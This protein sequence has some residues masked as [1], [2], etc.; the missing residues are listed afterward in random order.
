MLKV[1]S[2][3]SGMELKSRLDLT[4]IFCDVDHFYQSFEHYCRSIPQLTAIAGEKRCNSR[5]S[6]SE[7]MTIVT[8][9][10]GS[11]YKTF[12]ENFILSRYNR[13]GKRHSLIW[14]VTTVLSS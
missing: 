10:H 11:G 9:F 8:A 14:L 7:V 1:V 2:Q 12:K 13:T 4:E 6:L 3:V 5:L